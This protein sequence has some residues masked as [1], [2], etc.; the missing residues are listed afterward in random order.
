MDHVR[1][2][3]R[4]VLTSLSVN[5]VRHPHHLSIGHSELVLSNAKERARNLIVLLSSAVTPD[6]I[7]D[8]VSLLFLLFARMGEKAR[9]TLDS[10]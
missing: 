3:G 6:L 1:A 9:K 5:E 4:A 2:H 10:R 8:P 7:G